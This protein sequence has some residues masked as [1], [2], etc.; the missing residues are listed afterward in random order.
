MIKKVLKGLEINVNDNMPVAVS[1][2]MVEGTI[3]G[4]IVFLTIAGALYTMGKLKG[5]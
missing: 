1:K 5:E 3:N 2:G 4:T